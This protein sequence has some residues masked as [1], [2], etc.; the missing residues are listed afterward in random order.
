MKLLTIFLI[1]TA[2]TGCSTAGNT[3]LNATLS[4]KQAVLKIQLGA[5]V[6]KGLDVDIDMG[7]DKEGSWLTVGGAAGGAVEREA[8]HEATVKIVDSISK[9]AIEGAKMGFAP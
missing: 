2:L 1:L 3:K 5:N 4:G 7:W 9:R 8:G 6:K